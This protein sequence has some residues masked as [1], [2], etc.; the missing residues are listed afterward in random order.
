MDIQI[1]RATEQRLRDYLDG[2]GEVL[3]T[4]QRRDNFARYAFGLIGDG[5]R[6]SMEPIAARAGASTLLITQSLEKIGEMSCNPA[7]GGI[8]K[9]TLVREIDA[10]LSE[11]K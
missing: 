3:G 2:I 10:I 4:P 9:G 5:D 6:K 8:A 1:D 11:G 7:I